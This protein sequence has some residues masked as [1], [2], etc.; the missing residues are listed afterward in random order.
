MCS[1]E[2]ILI[3]Y[4]TVLFTYFPIKANP[5]LSIPVCYVWKEVT[6]SL[7]AHFFAPGRGAHTTP[8]QNGN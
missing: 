4:F 2:I 3:P 8:T 6:H 7:R 5:P 1:E